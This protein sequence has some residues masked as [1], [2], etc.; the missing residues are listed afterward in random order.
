MYMYMYMYTHTNTFQGTWRCI[1]LSRLSLRYDSIAGHQWISQSSLSCKL[2]RLIK[3]RVVIRWQP[4]HQSIA[5]AHCTNYC[6]YLPSFVRIRF[7]DITLALTQDKCML[8][9]HIHVLL[10]QLL[11]ACNKTRKH[12]SMLASHDTA[13]FESAK[14]YEGVF[15]A[16]DSVPMSM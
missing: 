13:A 5:R 15:R 8:Q 7:G 1:Y 16:V 2:E 6:P 10:C 14:S 4:H 12:A 9:G 3:L 11:T